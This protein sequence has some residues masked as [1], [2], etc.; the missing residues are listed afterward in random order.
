MG[1]SNEVG[2]RPGGWERL[3]E[4]E[5][6][7]SG[8]RRKRKVSDLPP[9]LRRFLLV[10]L[11]HHLSKLHGLTLQPRRLLLH[12]LQLLS[13]RLQRVH[14]LLRCSCCSCDLSCSTSPSLLLPPPLSS[15]RL[16]R[17]PRKQLPP[18]LPR[19]SLC[20]SY[21]LGDLVAASLPSLV[22]LLLQQLLHAQIRIL[23]LELAQQ[24]S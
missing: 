20:I 1:S 24:P 12:V 22:L 8:G 15:H 5:E 18:L 2:E 13:S 6:A 10:V 4:R 11:A 21:F 9:F 7:E 17:R 3:E 19:L 14:G 16:H 23:P